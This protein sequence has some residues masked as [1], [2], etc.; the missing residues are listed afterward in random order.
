MKILKIMLPLI[1]AISLVVGISL[2]GLAAPGPNGAPEAVQ[3]DNAMP[4]GE[5][6]AWGKRLP[7]DNATPWGGP[8]AWGR[9]LPTDNA[10]PWGGSP[11]WGRRLPKMQAGKV[12]EI[13]VGKS[14]FIIQQGENEPVEIAVDNVTKYFKVRAPKNLTGLLQH[15]RAPEPRNDVETSGVNPDGPVNM[16]LLMRNRMVLRYQPVAVAVAD[17]TR[18]VVP[19]K[20]K[21]LNAGRLKKIKGFDRLVSTP[22]AAAGPSP[23]GLMRKGKGFGQAISTPSTGPMLSQVERKAKGKNSRLNLQQFRR[24]GEKATF[25]D[26]EVDDR[27]AVRLVPGQDKP[28]ARLVLIFKVSPYKKIAGTITA[29]SSDNQTITIDPSTEGEAA[30]FNYNEDTVFYL[31]GTIAVVPGQFAR[32]VYEVEGMLAKMVRVWPEGAAEFAEPGG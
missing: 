32:A 2:P 25:D 13:D 19:R 10:T 22:V 30:T 24:F 23:V 8:P 18:P 12:I 14:Y 15:R 1:V 16:G 26:I 20:P 3:T 5:P 9:R 6:P 21:L 28:V 17:D 11:A 27:V 31:K 29:V 7:A 4:W